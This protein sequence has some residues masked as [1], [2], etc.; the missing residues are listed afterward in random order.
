MEGTFLSESQRF[1]L[2][3]LRRRMEIMPQVFLPDEKL[4]FYRTLGALDDNS[5][6]ESSTHQQAAVAMQIL[7]KELQQIAVRLGKDH[8]LYQ[9]V[10]DVLQSIAPEMVA[11]AKRQAENE[12]S[13]RIRTMNERMVAGQA[14]MQDFY[15]W[16]ES[17]P[18][19]KTENI[20]KEKK[21]ERKSFIAYLFEDILDEE[22]KEELTQYVKDKLEDKLTVEIVKERRNSF[23]ERAKTHI[24][25][26]LN[27]EKPNETYCRR[28]NARENILKMGWNPDDMEMVDTFLSIV[29][30]VPWGKTREQGE[31]VLVTLLTKKVSSWEERQSLIDGM[32]SYCEVAAHSLYPD[33]NVDPKFQVEVAKLLTCAAGIVSKAEYPDDPQFKEKGEDYEKKILD[34]AIEKAV[35]NITGKDDPEDLKDPGNLKSGIYFTFNNR[36][37]RAGSISQLD[38]MLD[39]I[40]LHTSKDMNAEFNRIR[41]RAKDQLTEQPV[42]YSYADAAERKKA[43]SSMRYAVDKL[44]HS[45]NDEYG[46]KNLQKSILEYKDMMGM[47]VSPEEIE[48]KRSD[49]FKALK[50]YVK[51]IPENADMGSRRKLIYACDIL[52]GLQREINFK[53]NGRKYEGEEKIVKKEKKEYAFELDDC[54]KVQAMIEYNADE[55][56]RMIPAAAK[57]CMVKEYNTQAYSR[58]MQ[59][60]KDCSELDTGHSIREIESAYMELRIAAKAFEKEQGI[61]GMEAMKNAK[62]PEE[63]EMIHTVQMLSRKGNSMARE[64]LDTS[65]MIRDRNSSMRDMMY[66]VLEETEER[67]EKQ[68]EKEKEKKKVKENAVLKRK[69]KTAEAGKGIHISRK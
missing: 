3:K 10:L 21:E 6:K 32:T 9:D 53:K 31:L 35:K 69:E 26:E 8:S 40:Q 65:K 64:L 11:E 38:E 5:V 27:K 56:R 45:G 54:M 62:T 24:E 67:M 41:S 43:V 59:A 1:Q 39:Q 60:I 2:D 36:V 17:E 14:L 12:E 18:E 42:E 28:L 49:L 61:D 33:G 46:I 51:N 68:K 47:E 57:I 30:N 58:M 66:R 48:K 16:I 13:I 22:D 55:M 37:L 52:C 19:E 7:L 15:K 20:N 44:I 29:D 34:I 50:D 63:R 23:M 25:E 4:V